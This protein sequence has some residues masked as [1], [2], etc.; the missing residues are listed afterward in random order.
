MRWN[1]KGEADG[2]TGA[3]EKERGAWKQWT[4]STFTIDL[5]ENVLMKPFTI[6]TRYIMFKIFKL[7]KEILELLILQLYILAIS[8][9][10]H[11]LFYDWWL[12]PHAFCHCGEWTNGWQGSLC[13]FLGRGFMFVSS[14]CFI[15]SIY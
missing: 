7:K 13:T 3:R 11:W 12:L 1:Y 8:S 2:Q 5:E 6:H 14:G 10:V 9:C 4:G 15:L